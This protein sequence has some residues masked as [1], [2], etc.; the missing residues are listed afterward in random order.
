MLPIIY[1][2]Y[3]LNDWGDYSCPEGLEIPTSGECT[4]AFNRIKVEYGYVNTRSITSGSWNH[5]AT[6]CNVQ[7]GKKGGPISDMSPYF[8]KIAKSKP[9]SNFRKICRRI[10]K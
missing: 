8:N 1:S 9:I 2:A 3:S 4:K 7:S 6:K 10:G 5:V